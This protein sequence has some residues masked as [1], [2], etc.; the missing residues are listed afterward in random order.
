[1]HRTIQQILKELYENGWE[2]ELLS[3][4]G[5]IFYEFA[6]KYYKFATQ[7]FNAPSGLVWNELEFLLEN[8]GNFLARVDIRSYP[9]HHKTWVANLLKAIKIPSSP[10]VSAW[11]VQNVVKLLS[12]PVLAEYPLVRDAILKAA[13]RNDLDA[14]HKMHLLLEHSE[15]KDWDALEV[16]AQTLL[17]EKGRRRFPKDKVGTLVGELVV[18]HAIYRLAR[19]LEDVHPSEHA[20]HVDIL[21]RLFEQHS[22]SFYPEELRKL[23]LITFAGALAVEG[24]TI[25]NRRVNPQYFIFLKSLGAKRSRVFAESLLEHAPSWVRLIDDRF[26]P[27]SSPGIKII[28]SKKDLVS[29]ALALERFPTCHTPLYGEYADKLLFTPYASGVVPVVAVAKDIQS[30]RVIGRINMLLDENTGNIYITSVPFGRVG[31]E[32]Y[33]EA[34]EL[35]ARKINKQLGQPKFRRILVG[36]FSKEA[37]TYRLPWGVHDTYL[38]HERGEKEGVYH[39]TGRVARHIE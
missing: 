26:V 29:Q 11:Y 31:T 19:L 21:N 20:L 5:R 38:T 8:M 33:V 1:M 15:R 32:H 24:R 7:R 10:P 39:F 22:A 27:S 30:N 12:N 17:Q 25:K 35:V 23:P 36:D 34:A 28:L 2:R 18:R 37:R 13:R 6:G 16:Q 4:L 9:E 3:H 14:F